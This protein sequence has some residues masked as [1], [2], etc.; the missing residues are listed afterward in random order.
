MHNVI[1]FHGINLYLSQ[2]QLC[3]NCTNQYVTRNI[4]SVCIY[5]H[6]FVWGSIR[7]CMTL[8]FSSVMAEGEMV[9][10]KC[11]SWAVCGLKGYYEF[12][13]FGWPT[14]Y[15]RLLNLGFGCSLISAQI[16]H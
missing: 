10:L 5:T 3:S 11:S 1:P 4:A 12:G 13:F 2:I 8:F 15:S 9:W 7:L 14:Y 6:S 16:S